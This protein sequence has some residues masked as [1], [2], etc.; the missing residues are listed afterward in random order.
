MPLDTTM[1]ADM[2]PISFT[3]EISCNLFC[4]LKKIV[5]DPLGCELFRRAIAK[6]EASEGNLDKIKFTYLFYRKQRNVHSVSDAVSSQSARSQHY[7]S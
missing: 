6:Y 1:F 2:K 3:K 7:A 4:Y 5:E